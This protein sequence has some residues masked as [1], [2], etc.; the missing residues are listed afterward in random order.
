MMVRCSFFVLVCL[1]LTA[2]IVEDNTQRETDAGSSMGG[3]A[4][5]EI[6]CNESLCPNGSITISDDCRCE[7]VSDCLAEE[8]APCADSE[9]SVDVPG[10]CCARC[11]PECSATDDCDAE[12]VCSDGI[13]IQNCEAVDCAPCPEGFITDLDPTACCSCTPA[14]GPDSPFVCTEDQVCFEGLCIE[15]PDECQ[16]VACEACEPGTQPVDNGGCCPD[17]E[18]LECPDI[19]CEPC[20]PGERAIEE[21]GCCPTCVPADCTCP[22]VY[23]PVC[24][25]NG[26]VYGNRCEAECVG[27]TE[28]ERCE[29]ECTCTEEYDPVCGRNGQTYPNPCFAEC[30]GVRNYRPGVCDSECACPDVYRPVCGS[31]GFTYPNPCVAECERIEIFYPGECGEISCEPG[32]ECGDLCD[33]IV[34]CFDQ[35]CDGRADLER[36]S[37]ECCLACS[38]AGVPLEDIVGPIDECAEMVEVVQEI[39][40]TNFCNPRDCDEPP[41]DNHFYIGFGQECAYID[42]ECGPGEDY[43]QDECGCGCV[44]RPCECDDVSDAPVCSPEGVQFRNACE[45]RCEGYYGLRSC[46]ESCVCPSVY[47]PVCG[48]DGQTYGNECLAACVD[49]PIVRDGDCYASEL[50]PDGYETSCEDACLVLEECADADC[51]EEAAESLMEECR[52]LCRSEGPL[53]SEVVCSAYSC[54]EAIEFLSLFTGAPAF[55]DVPADVCP[56]PAVATYFGQ[57]P[58][59]CRLIEFECPDGETRFD[60]RCGCGCSS[61]QECPIEGVNARYVS[62]DPAICEAVTAQCPDGSESFGFG[63]ESDACG[64]GCQF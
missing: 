46:E 63:M 33:R 53:I 50:C 21:G 57:S 16:E 39:A 26:N 54:G 60:G 4:G 38:E 7:C 42:Y 28:V 61:V 40:D 9:T 51:D 49:M 32:T 31:D 19:P 2:C 41:S 45:A 29:E 27:V 34:G 6:E 3:Q 37:T 30:Q 1:S 15:R 5:C 43:F 59:V 58:D 62:R 35:E 13:C 48:L 23:R 20:A 52:A 14:C 55:C 56:D 25:E 17:C 22:S 18:P 11:V 47:E 10:E 8:C 24:D 64:C 12:S 44:I 36:I